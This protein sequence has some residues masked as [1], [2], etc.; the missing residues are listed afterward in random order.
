M[1][2]ENGKYPAQPTGRVEVGEHENGCLIAKMEFDLG[3]G[4]TISNTFWLTTKDGG[5]NTRSIET[6]KEIFGW[7]GADPFW[8][9]DHAAEFVD[10]SVQ[11]VIENHTFTGRDGVE[12]IAPEVKWVNPTG[13]GMGGA[14]VANGDRTSLLAKYGAKL[15]AVSGGTPVSKKPVPQSAPQKQPD[16]PSPVAPGAM[17]DKPPVTPKKAVLPSDM[18]ACWKA[19]TDAMAN[20]PRTEVEA[21]WFEIIKAV[22]GDKQQPEYTPG[23]WGMIMDQLRKTFDNL[24]F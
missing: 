16:L 13:G 8:L 7:D 4:R 11:L 15:R 12:R 9:E 14:Q 24:P 5:V 10:V 17:G 20:K 1:Q 6:L 18:N 3:E 23:D 21:K 22:H 2:I 19:L